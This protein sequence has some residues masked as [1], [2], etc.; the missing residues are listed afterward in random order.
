MQFELM[1]ADEWFLNKVLDN[2]GL[3]RNPHVQS[4]CKTTH[5]IGSC[6]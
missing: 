1:I 4:P 2:R 3:L 6:F 5:H